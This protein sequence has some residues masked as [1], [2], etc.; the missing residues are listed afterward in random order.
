MLAQGFLCWG[1]GF[2]LGLLGVGVFSGMLH[3]AIA[4]LH[5][6]ETAYHMRPEKSTPKKPKRTERFGDYLKE[7]ANVATQTRKQT[8]LTTAFIHINFPENSG[9]W[10][11]RVPGLSVTAFKRS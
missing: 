1:F 9:Y 3:N 6:P 2:S 11:L 4:Q 7:C 5:I 10:R 8:N